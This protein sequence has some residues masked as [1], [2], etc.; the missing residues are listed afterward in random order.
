MILGFR[1]KENRKRER[2]EG[3]KEKRERRRRRRK[4]KKKKK[5]KKKSPMKPRASAR[6]SVS[7]RPPS[8]LRRATHGQPRWY[9]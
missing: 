6:L 5:E 4:K 7:V 1:G 8:G 9:T 2:R 3:G